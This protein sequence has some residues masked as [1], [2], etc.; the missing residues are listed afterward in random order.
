MI[1]FTETEVEVGLPGISDHSPLVVTMPGHIKTGGRP[2]KFLNYMAEHSFFLQTVT[3]AWRVSS[4]GRP[5][6]QVWNKLKAVKQAMKELHR[7]E[8]RDIQ[9]KIHATKENLENV[10]KLLSENRTYVLLQTQEREYISLLKKWL[11]VDEVA[12]KQK[13]RNLWLSVGDSNHKYF[14]SAMRE[15]KYKQNILPDQ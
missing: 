2:F 12:L 1:S 13:S 3:E 4:A 11:H 15:N 8:Y 10:Q 7:Q 6:Q 14:F 9:E 5:M